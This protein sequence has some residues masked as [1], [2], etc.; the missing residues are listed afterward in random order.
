MIKKG[1]INEGTIS[2]PLSH[3]LVHPYET[4]CKPLRHTI[5]L[6]ILILILKMQPLQQQLF[7]QYPHRYVW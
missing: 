1:V 5:Y 3:L 4:G 6:Q 2:H 7:S